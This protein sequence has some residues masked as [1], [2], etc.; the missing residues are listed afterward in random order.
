[1]SEVWNWSLNKLL[2][3]DHIEAVHK[4]NILYNDISFL[5]FQQTFP[6]G[7]HKT[8]S[9]TILVQAIFLVKLP[10]INNEARLT[11]KC[12]LKNLQRGHLGSLFQNITDRKM[13]NR[14]VTL[15]HFSQSNL[16]V[17]TEL[18][19]VLESSSS[20]SAALSI[21]SGGLYFGDCSDLLGRPLFFPTK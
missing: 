7:N 8:A 3:R 20:P 9:L 16:K 6:C 21:L 4:L 1:M 12:E 15:I 13:S 19:P 14:C 10:K 5:R 18:W 17:Q 11:W 2:T